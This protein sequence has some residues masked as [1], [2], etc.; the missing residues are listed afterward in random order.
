MAAVACALAVGGTVASGAAAR[1]APAPVPVAQHVSVQP[2]AAPAAPLQDP[3]P[4]PA[5]TPAAGVVPTRL[6]IPDIGVDAALPP[7]S[8]DENRVLLPPGDLDTAGWYTGSAVPGAVGPAILAGH[9]DDTETAGVFARLHELQPGASITVQLSDGTSRQYRMDRSEDVA[10]A[11]F[12]T[13]QVYGPT[14]NSQLR[15]ITCNGPYDFDAMHYRNN[16]V[17]FA[18]PVE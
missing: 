1:P 4:L 7:L 10:K 5:D 13:E 9:V 8:L 15:I 14:P 6:L 18:V 17:V 2:A 12:P 3:Q 11:E 16:L